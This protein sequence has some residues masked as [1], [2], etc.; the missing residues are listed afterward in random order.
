M[1]NQT[2]KQLANFVLRSHLQALHNAALKLIYL[3]Q[4]DIHMPA[5]RKIL[6]A[7]NVIDK[8]LLKKFDVRLP[9][10][11]LLYYALK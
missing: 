2:L 6:K 8:N 3:D 11:R 10:V 1:H 4:L 5:G 7:H 9:I